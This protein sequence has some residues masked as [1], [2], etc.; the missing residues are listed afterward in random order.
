MIMPQGKPLKLMVALLGGISLIILVGIMRTQSHN[1]LDLQREIR[2]LNAKLAERSKADQVQ[3]KCAE[4]ARKVFDALGYSKKEFA[5]FESHYTAKLDKCAMRVLHTD[6]QTTRGN[7]IWTYVN[8]R[9][10]FEDKPYGT[11]AWHTETSRKFMIVP[12]V[13]CEV[14]LPNREQKT[15]YSIE[16]F[17]E[18]VKIYMEGN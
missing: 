11:Y 17:E 7:V 14:T 4:Q 15:C 8:V 5:A 16:E 2:D 9:D 12:P 10:A 3:A 1:I 6:A 13:I 18:L